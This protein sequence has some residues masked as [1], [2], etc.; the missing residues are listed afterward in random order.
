MKKILL[1]IAFFAASFVSMAQEG[2]G[3]TTTKGT[4]DH[5]GLIVSRVANTAAVTSPKERYAYV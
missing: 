1:S 2:V 3:T 5:R 4:I